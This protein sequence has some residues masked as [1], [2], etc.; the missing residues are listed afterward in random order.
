M[1]A[2]SGWDQPVGNAIKLSMYVLY[3]GMRAE[4]SNFQQ[5]EAVRFGVVV[6]AG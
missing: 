1:L 2:V 5:A 3:V 6:L 4:Y